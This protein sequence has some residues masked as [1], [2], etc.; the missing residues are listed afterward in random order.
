[1]RSRFNVLPFSEAINMYIYLL[2]L[3]ISR[4]RGDHRTGYHVVS[5]DKFSN[6]A[7][8]KY[9]I[10]RFYICDFAYESPVQRYGLV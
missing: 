5:S 10:Q 8:L 9:I 3:V 7:R 6:K 2:D 1:M 4:G